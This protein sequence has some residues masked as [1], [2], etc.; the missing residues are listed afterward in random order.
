[1][2]YCCVTPETRIEEC[3]LLALIFLLPFGAALAFLE[4]RP[5]LKDKLLLSSAFP[6]YVLTLQLL[7]PLSDSK[8]LSIALRFIHCRQIPPAV[9]SLGRMVQHY[10]C[11]N[12]TIFCSNTF[13]TRRTHLCFQASQP[14][15][16]SGPSSTALLRCCS[17][18]GSMLFIRFLAGFVCTEAP[19]YCAI[20]FNSA[21]VVT[22]DPKYRFGTLATN[23]VWRDTSK[24]LA[25]K[26]KIFENSACFAPPRE[27]WP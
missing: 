16:V 6:L 2:S 23:K 17:G 21:R 14:S 18:P 22:R 24:N 1:M 27:I 26:T 20:S 7:S 25:F 12:H 8:Y 19:E 5:G 4:S 15:V 13:R 9:R 10:H 3:L 11:I